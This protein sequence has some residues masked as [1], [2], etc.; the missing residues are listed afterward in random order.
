MG[1][2]SRE[3]QG[4]T[5][6]LLQVRLDSQCIQAEAREPDWVAH[7]ESHLDCKYSNCYWIILQEYNKNK[8]KSAA[9]NREVVRGWDVR[10]SIGAV[11]DMAAVQHLRALIM[12]EEA[13]KKA[14]AV[15]YNL[16]CY[17]PTTNCDFSLKNSIPLVALQF[18][19]ASLRLSHAITVL[20]QTPTVTRRMPEHPWNTKG[21]INMCLRSPLISVKLRNFFRPK[22]ST[23]RLM[24]LQSLKNIRPPTTIIRNFKCHCLMQSRI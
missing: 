19:P 6:C 18:A 12:T 22:R 24:R 3:D 10:I 23:V 13:Q 4:N 14:E 9:I 21:S 11:L 15:C 16:F 17:I 5:S 1:R 7:S 20:L 8:L 2:P